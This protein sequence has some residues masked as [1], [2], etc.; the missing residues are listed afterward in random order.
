MNSPRAYAQYLW[1]APV[2][3]L[4]VLAAI[5]AHHPREA[6]YRQGVVTLFEQAERVEF[7]VWGDNEP[8]MVIARGDTRK[9]RAILHGI[10]DSW[11]IAR[12]PAEPDIRVDLYLTPSPPERREPELVHA[13]YHTTCRQLTVADTRLQLSDRALHLGAAFRALVPQPR[14]PSACPKEFVPE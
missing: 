13:Y 9:F 7:Y 1:L 6:R 10:R 14:T 12:C 3:A 5:L 4:L 8:A 11:V 2:G